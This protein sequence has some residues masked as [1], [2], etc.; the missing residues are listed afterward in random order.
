MFSRVRLSKLHS[1]EEAEALA[2]QRAV[3]LAQEE[4]FDKVIFALDC[5]SLSSAPQLFFDG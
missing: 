3:L 4:G 2:L 1:P 5:L